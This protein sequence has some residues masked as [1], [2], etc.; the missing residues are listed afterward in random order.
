MFWCLV[1]SLHYPFER[2]LRISKVTGNRI[3]IL[4]DHAVFSESLKLVLGDDYEV[5][6]TASSKELFLQLENS[7]YDLLLLDLNFPD[8]NGFAIFSELRALKHTL[9]VLLITASSSVALERDSRQLGFN[10]CFHKAEKLDTL[11]E[12][13]NAL[14]RGKEWWPDISKVKNTKGILKQHGLTSRQFDVLTLIDKGYTN[15]DI[16][17]ALYVSESTVKS[18]ITA[19]FTQLAVKNRTSCLRTARML[20]LLN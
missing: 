11:L 7:E 8:D 19:L 5:T 10:G 13:I 4:D 2:E 18:H 6:V 16:A 1:I 15:S 14:L 12:A 3:I 17:S 20:G 9:P